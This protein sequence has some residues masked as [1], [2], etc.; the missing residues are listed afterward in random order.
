M[1]SSKFA[2]ALP[3][4]KVPAVCK[5]KT[6]PDDEGPPPNP[7][8]NEVIQG[9][10]SLHGTYFG[11][12]YDRDGPLPMDDIDGFLWKSQDPPPPNGELIAMWW[13][14]AVPQWNAAI[15]LYVGGVLKVHLNTP[16]WTYSW[17]PD[18]DTGTFDW[19]N[20]WWIGE[21]TGRLHN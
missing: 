12:R 10:F 19:R 3:P 2:G 16:T 6:R 21:K 9:E 8:P 13:N 18:F 4:F 17:V 1:T 11:D 14:P 7:L 20:I 5:D 15:N